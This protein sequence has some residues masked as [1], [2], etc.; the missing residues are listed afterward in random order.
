MP[1][2]M[3][4]EK[5]GSDGP[6]NKYANQPEQAPAS[7]G[8]KALAA[9][10]AV[11]G[12]SDL[13]ARAAVPESPISRALEGPAPSY[14][15]RLVQNLPG[16]LMNLPAR[17]NVNTP[18]MPVDADQPPHE[19]HRTTLSQKWNAPT[20]SMSQLAEENKEP[21]MLQGA[22]DYWQ[23]IAGALTH[24]GEA[25]VKDPAGT[26]ADIGGAVSGLGRARVPEAITE[27]VKTGINTPGS[28]SLALAGSLAAGKAGAAV[29]YGLS[30]LAA[31]AKAAGG[32][33][34]QPLFTEPP[35]PGA[36]RVP[37]WTGAEGPPSKKL[38]TTPIESA[39][40]SGRLV[41][42]RPAASLGVDPVAPPAPSGTLAT[43][44]EMPAKVLTMPPPDDGFPVS[45]PNS[46]FSKRLAQ[47]REAHGLK[48]NVLASPR[49]MGD[50]GS[51]S[52]I[53]RPRNS[54]QAQSTVLDTP[55][56]LAAAKA[57]ADAMK[58]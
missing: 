17:L 28:K 24:P 7:I 11:P 1:D 15:Q 49:N 48:P 34:R 21:D 9:P 38:S 56:K 20:P 32:E 36:N 46:P 45:D 3:P 52:S 33:L 29:G 58:K 14:R 22:K 4:W 25:F 5:Y 2:Q 35:G 44:P 16:S 30:K 13:K 54:Y 23:G 10:A 18:G 31:G 12:S 27:G 41:P 50:V 39:L 26:L 43:T 42:P 6:W 8:G 19:L 40:P 37:I 57:L 47:V 51:G 53:P 55:E